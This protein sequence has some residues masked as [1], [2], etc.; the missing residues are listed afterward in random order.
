MRV[1]RMIAGRRAFAGDTPASVIAAVLEREP[2]P[3]VASSEQVAH[4][5]LDGIIRTCLAKNPD[6]R[7]S[8]GHDV[9]LALRRLGH[10]ADA[11]SAV[12]PSKARS[13]R[14]VLPWVIATVA[15]ATTIAAPYRTPSRPAG[16]VAGPAMRSFIDF[17]NA[18]L[19][20]PLLSPDARYLSL[21]LVLWSWRR[22]TPDPCAPTGRRR[23]YLAC[24]HRARPASDVVT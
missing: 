3:L 5:A 24:G 4:P 19:V 16:A 8:S 15:L 2:A 6:D 7:W 21:Y 9:W 18:W 10:P 22:G 20:M 17:P 12:A 13:R 23:H 11:S 14:T 1:V